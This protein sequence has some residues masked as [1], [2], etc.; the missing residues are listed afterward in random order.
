MHNALGITASLPATAS[1]FFDRP[2]RVIHGEAFANAIRAQITDPSVRRI[3]AERLIG[4][5]DQFSDSTDILSDPHW[6]PLLRQLYA[7]E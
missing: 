6:R 2:F 3:A 1:P 5:V 4:G 7:Y